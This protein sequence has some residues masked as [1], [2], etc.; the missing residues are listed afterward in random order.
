MAKKKTAK[1]AAKKELEMLVVGSKV[2]AVIKEAGTEKK[3]MMAGDF[4]AKLNESVHAT[5]AAAIAR[6]EAN[7]RSTVRP[8]DV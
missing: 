4:L 2:K 5:I 1:K 7:K 8:Q 3:M 6:A